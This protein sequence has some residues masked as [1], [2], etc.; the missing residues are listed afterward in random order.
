MLMKKKR[1]RLLVLLIVLAM[2]FSLLPTTL[3]ETAGTPG[4]GAGQKFDHTY[5][6]NEGH[7]NR[8][9]DRRS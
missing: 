4:A 7:G 2:I 5:E 1:S 8:D 9:T 3:A 6:I